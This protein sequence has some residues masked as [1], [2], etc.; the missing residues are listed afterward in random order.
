MPALVAGGLEAVFF[1]FCSRFLTSQL[2]LCCNGLRGFCLILL[3]QLFFLYIARSFAILVIPN[4]KRHPT[5][6]PVGLLIPITRIIQA[7]AMCQD[8]VPL[9]SVVPISGSVCRHT[10]KV[11]AGIRLDGCNLTSH[12]RAMIDERESSREARLLFE[13]MQVSI[14][15]PHDMSYGKGTTKF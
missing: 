1:F 8:L 11:H 15:I 6:G 9:H 14:K 12:V 10:K 3:L 7:L 4:S 13:M 5:V 2:P